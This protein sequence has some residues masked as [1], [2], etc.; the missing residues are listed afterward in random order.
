[1]GVPKIFSWLSRKFEQCIVKTNPHRPD[2]FCIDANSLIHPICYDIKELYID[3]SITEEELEEK[4][5]EQI[6]NEIKNLNDYFNPTCYTY[7][8]V[9]GIAPLA[10][11]CHQRKRR[12]KSVMETELRNSIKKKHG[13]KY[14]DWQNT[15]ISP[16][17]EFMEKLDIAFLKEFSNTKYKYSSYKECGEGEHKLIQ[18]MKKDK[19]KKYTIWGMDADLIF[20][21]MCSEINDIILCHDDRK[22]K[23]YIII[24]ELKKAFHNE[25]IDLAKKEQYE[26]DVTMDYTKDITFA[27]FFL[28]NDFLPKCLS[29]DIYSNGLIK[30]LSTFIKCLKDLPDHRFIQC[31]KIDSIFLK[32]FIEELL[33]FEYGYFKNMLTI[34]NIR[35]LNVAKKAEA[36][37]NPYELDTYNIDNLVGIEKYP[38]GQYNDVKNRNEF[39]KTYFKANNV[40]FYKKYI[41]EKYLETLYWTAKYYFETCEDWLHY[42]KFDYAPFL[43]DLHEYLTKYEYVNKE[44]KN[45][46]VHP[47]TQMLSIIPPQLLNLVPKKYH[48]IMKD[49][50]YSTLF[51]RTITLDYAHKDKYYECLPSM[52]HIDLFAIT[53]IV[54][55]LEV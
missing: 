5:I 13:I 12:Y 38:L 34:N 16:Y 10:K 1:M 9:D 32:K 45:E 15:K 53:D 18:D 3:T 21:S 23:E 29:L 40:L 24:D 46:A 35:V 7:I 41:C 39:Y 55:S 6:I 11:I 2:I 33:K 19:N 44:V 42:Y 47:M 27:C 14:S 52:M 22:E 54:K 25:L 31:N 30:I 20:L 17:T 26:I 28:G 49:E 51:P 8:A 37:T 4:M 50:Y 48:N 43:V 36:I